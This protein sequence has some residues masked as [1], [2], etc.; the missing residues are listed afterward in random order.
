MLL[1]REPESVEVIDAHRSQHATLSSLADAFIAS[2]EF[3][4]RLGGQR[5]PAPIGVERGYWAQPTMVEHQVAPEVLD[6]LAE[7]IRAQWTAL[8][9]QDPYWSV[10]TADKFRSARIDA[11]ALEEFKISGVQAAS[12]IDLTI[13]RSTRDAPRGVCL[14]LGC[15]VGRVT[16]HLSRRFDRVIAV[17]ISPGNLALCRRY[18]EEESIDNVETVLVRD[19]ADFDALP[20]FDFFY[21]VIVLQHNSP[22]VQRHILQVL[23]SKL[24]VGGQ[25]L[26]QAIA[27]QPGYVFTIDRYLATPSPEMEV[28]SLPMSAIMQI[29]RD[30]GLVL[31]TA[32]LDTWAG[33][34]GSYTFHG[35]RE[36]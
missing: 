28:H 14:E 18:M 11:A 1:G 21:S 6:R 4:Q 26:F 10:L 27:D 29:I 32:R 15:G 8:G 16:R 19:L 20:A 33:F 13:G 30:A 24:R 23:L 25:Y 12:L 3:R 17:D 9:E 22:P 36:G 34:Y 31:D 5:Q 7:R 2:D 35:C